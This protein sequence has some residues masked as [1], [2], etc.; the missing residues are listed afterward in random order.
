MKYSFID[1]WLYEHGTGGSS[2]DI[3]RSA[4][5]TLTAVG[6]IMFAVLSALGARAVINT[7]PVPFTLQVLFVLLSGMVLGPRAGAM[8]QILYVSMGIM[9]MPVFA[10][11]PYC[12]IAYLLGPT[13]GYLIGFI[14]AAF[15]VG[16]VRDML[17][18]RSPNKL[19]RL[20][21]LLVAGI[22]GVAALYSFG[23]LWLAAWLTV[24]GKPFNDSLSLAIKTGLLPFFIVDTLKAAG[25]SCMA[26]VLTPRP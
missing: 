24:A 17:I 21:S 22:A 2:I 12:G 26:M 15:T 20:F 11:P 1:R 9:G 4:D 18:K 3:T 7:V 14:A 5:L 10:A 25:A 13:G 16:I 8:S 19:S 6:V 23:V